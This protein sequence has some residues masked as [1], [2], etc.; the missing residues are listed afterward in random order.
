MKKGTII[1]LIL[2]FSISL[3]SAGWWADITGRVVSSSC[4]DS[5]GGLN[6]YKAG[7]TIGPA[8]PNIDEIGT[9]TD[10]C[11]NDTYLNEGGCDEEGWTG[12]Y[13]Y[14]CLDGCKD[15]ACIM[16]CKDSDGGVNYSTLG[17]IKGLNDNSEYVENEDHCCE[18]CDGYNPVNNANSLFE[19]TCEG[20]IVSGFVWEH[21]IN[22]CFNGTCI[23]EKSV[24]AL[25]I[26]L[27]SF[28]EDTSILIKINISEAEE[29]ANGSLSQLGFDFV[30]KDEISEEGLGKNYERFIRFPVIKSQ[31]EITA[32][33]LEPDTTYEICLSGMMDKVYTTT[34]LF[35]C[36]TIKTETEKPA[37]ALIL[38]NYDIDVES[39]ELINNWM[40]EVSLKN[41]SLILEQKTLNSGMKDAEL[42]NILSEEYKYS[43]L[44]YVVIIGRDLPIPIIASSLTGPSYSI[45]PYQSLSFDVT[46]NDNGFVNQ[47]NSLKEIS[48][49]VIRPKDD[50][51]MQLYFTRLIGYYQGEN[52]FNRKLILANGMIPSESSLNITDFISPRYSSS[53]LEYIGGINSYDDIFAAQ[54]FK[55][56]YNDSLSKGN[57]IIVLNVHGAR[58][59]HFP[60]DDRCIDSDFIESANPNFLAIFAISCSIGYFMEDNSPLNSYIFSGNSLVGVGAPVPIIDVNG[61]I[62]KDAYD[63]FVNKNKNI[64][65]STM[66]YGLTVIGD[67]FIKLK[68]SNTDSY[69]ESILNEFQQ[70]I[71]QDCQGCLLEDNCYPFN[72]RKNRNYCSIDKEF[73]SQLGTKELCENNFEC[74][75]NLCIDN[76]C[77]SQKLFRKIIN[78]FRKLFS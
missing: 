11:F 31:Y 26:S 8:Y 41:P 67:P 68:I 43:N 58:D 6:Y 49:S 42:Y 64:G 17:K 74:S 29:E 69:T 71:K 34:G 37:K 38:K 53:N 3:V 66:Q 72:Y 75:S 60:C 24:Q 70:E 18:N 36:Q 46:N 25:N 4:K 7:E 61:G 2:V 73:V 33:N 15:G 13:S 22:G 5:D 55:N 32:S 50:I 59:F 51:Q 63:S 78:W 10:H 54:N 45:S 20:N 1:F 62:A 9:L 16:V 44:R 23:E 65:D 27:V 35:S 14:N 47:K 21:C 40:N 28:H 52:T 30:K 76:E 77:I 12:W 56:N 57:E 48:I 39:N 19:W